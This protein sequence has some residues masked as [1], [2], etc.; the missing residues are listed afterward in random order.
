MARIVRKLVALTGGAA[1]A[2][3]IFF[4]L[5]WARKTNLLFGHVKGPPEHLLRSVYA[6]AVGKTLR[7]QSN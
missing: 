3:G 5:K 1:N 7:L 4:F 2:F 6:L